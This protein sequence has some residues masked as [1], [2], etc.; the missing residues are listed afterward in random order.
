MKILLFGKDGQIGRHLRGLLPTLGELA[1]LGRDDVDL[2]DQNALMLALSVHRPDVIVNAAAYTA[3]D[4]AET[5]QDTATQVNVLAVSTLASYAKNAGALLVHY[6]SDYVFDGE[7][8]LP[9]TEADAPNPLNVYGATKL[10][11]ESAILQSA[12]DALI[13]RCSWVYSSQGKNFPATILRLARTRQELDV[14]ADQHGT[15]TSAALIADVTTMAIQ[16]HR[17]DALASGIYHLAAASDTTWHAFAQYLV[18]GAAARGAVLALSPD[19]IRAIASKDYPTAARRPHNSRLDATRLS[20]ALGIQP[21]SWN[22]YAD[23][24]LDQL[25]KRGGAA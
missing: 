24:V 14:V 22:V 2:R 1:A 19:R 7:K 25:F 16:Q 17:K 9:Y 23:R 18:A 8:S 15:P 21:D 4:Q 12:C 10:A 20:H 13:L 11:G 6:S 3:V 5:D